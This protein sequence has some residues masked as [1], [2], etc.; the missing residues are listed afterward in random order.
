MGRLRITGDGPPFYRFG[1]CVRYARAELKEHD[2]HLVGTCVAGW[3]PSA[4]AAGR[5]PLET[6]DDCYYCFI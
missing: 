3:S 6:Q 5:T 1:G 2:G 4:H